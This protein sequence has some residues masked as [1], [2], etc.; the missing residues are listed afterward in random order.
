M[1][2]KLT[3]ILISFLI[4]VLLINWI[5]PAPFLIQTR[6]LILG[7]FKLPLKVA[8]AFFHI[9]SQ[10]AAFVSLASQN[11][12]LT[13][14]L[15]KVQFNATRLNELSSENQR[16]RSLLS[17]KSNSPYRAEAAEVIGQDPGLFSRILII[18]K[19]LSHNLRS[20]MAVVTFSGVVGRL[21]EAGNQVSKVM[22]I[23]DPNSRLSARIERSREEGLL[24]GT[25]GP[26][27][28]LRY[29]SL[30]ADV[31]IGDEVVTSGGE[32]YP[33]GLLIGEV[34]SL[35]READGMAQYAIVKPAVKFSQ[36][37]EVLCLE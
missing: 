10:K 29:L 31:K 24:V 30:E 25:L 32:I 6:L 26:N 5:V 17:F 27:C 19:G 34:I 1:A 16:L 21:V 11:K 13:Q 33:K 37:E 15:A 28:R 3:I 20:D 35:G 14:E 23:T 12:Q 36:L 4:L 2:G 9:F 8:S 7:L 18:D 22:L